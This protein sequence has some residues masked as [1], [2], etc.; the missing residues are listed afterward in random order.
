MT[1]MAHLRCEAIAKSFGGRSVLRDV[2]LDV[3]EG[4]LTA[5]LGS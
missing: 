1:G 2:D 5:I 4:T 3:A